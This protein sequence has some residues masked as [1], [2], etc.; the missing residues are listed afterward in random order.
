[1]LNH[2]ELLGGIVPPGALDILRGQLTRIT[3]ENTSMLGSTALLSL[4][5]ALWSSSA[6]VKAMFK[7]MNVAYH[8]KEQ[9]S[10][11]VL[12]ATA[13][14]FTV[15]G[16]M[17]GLLVISVV[18]LMPWLVS[19]LPVGNEIAWA[20]RVAAYVAMAL[21]MS[22]ALAA[23]YRW[24]PSRE[25]AKWRWITPG[26]V[27]ALVAIASGSILFSWYV[28]NFRNDDATYG[29]L[30]AVIGMMSWLWISIT[31]IIVGAELNAEIEH[32]TARDSTTGPD[33]PLGKR[34]AH[35]ADN[36]GEAWPLARVKGAGTSAVRKLVAIFPWL[37]VLLRLPAN[38][39][40]WMSRNDR[41]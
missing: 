25:D 34:G 23:L 32:Q 18:V 16:A 33:R 6:G 2:I 13:L 22:L 1:M 21:V 29:S 17:A 20:V 14:L 39:R 5:I 41:P 4:A 40:T 9:R 37:S 8:E 7:A 11:I 31:V 35:M 12:S 30:G 24:G 26:G 36:V 27:F 15:G 3:A 10:L 38:V 28:A 19:F